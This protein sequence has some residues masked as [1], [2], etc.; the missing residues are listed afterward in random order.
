MSANEN[1]PKVEAKPSKAKALFVFWGLIIGAVASIALLKYSAAHLMDEKKLG[2]ELVEMQIHNH[3]TFKQNDAN[4]SETLFL[5]FPEAQSILIGS[6]YITGDTFKLFVRPTI[7]SID[8][9]KTID[10]YALDNDGLAIYEVRGDFKNGIASNLKISPWHPELEK[11]DNTWSWSIESI[12]SKVLNGFFYSLPAMDSV[13]ASVKSMAYSFVKLSTE[14]M[15]YAVN[16]RPKEDTN[17]SDI[18]EAK[19]VNSVR[20]E[21]SGLG[22][23][24]ALMSNEAGCLFTVLPEYIKDERFRLEIKDIACKDA[25]KASKIKGLYVIGEDAKIGVRA[26]DSGGIFEIDKGRKFD[27]LVQYLVPKKNLI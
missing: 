6:L 3:E 15:P 14:D 8:G 25:N 23:P 13:E 7:L 1:D 11:K 20:L 9:R 12:L 24:I 10:T 2:T 5:K 17:S 21:K 4:I 22:S 18:I 27:I 26:F 16:S 19:V